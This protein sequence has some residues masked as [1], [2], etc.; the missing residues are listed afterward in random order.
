MNATFRVSA[1]IMFFDKNTSNFNPKKA[2]KMSEN[3]ALR[4]SKSTWNALKFDDFHAENGTLH[5]KSYFLE[6]C[7][8]AEFL[9]GNFCNF[10]ANLLSKM[11]SKKLLWSTLL[12]SILQFKTVLLEIVTFFFNFSS[13]NIAPMTQIDPIRLKKSHEIWFRFDSRPY[14]R[15]TD[16]ATITDIFLNLLWHSIDSLRR[17]IV[18]YSFF[19]IKSGEE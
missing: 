1:F 13:I 18:S 2:K 7:F 5:Q 15:L 8:F 6:G 3:D 9:H 10:L 14:A 11:G 12:R 16:L 4:S 17:G 19:H